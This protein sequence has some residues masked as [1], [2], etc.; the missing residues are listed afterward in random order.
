M[1]GCSFNL[2]FCIAAFTS[3][4]AQMKCLWFITARAEAEKQLQKLGG[5]YYYY[6]SLVAASSYNSS[7][8]CCC[9]CCCGLYGTMIATFA[10]LHL[11]S[12]ILAHS[13]GK[14]VD[15]FLLGSVLPNHPNTAQ[16]L[17][18][19]SLRSTRLHFSSVVD[20]FAWLLESCEHCLLPLLCRT[21]IVLKIS[22]PSV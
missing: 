14:N 20:H 12:F 10:A 22:S 11:A 15:H 3:L 9:W 16:L 4:R 1:L 18:H 13:T 2:P 7:S 8:C 5:G 17:Q 19:R 6:F 21:K